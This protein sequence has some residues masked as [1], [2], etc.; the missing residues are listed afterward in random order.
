MAVD[1]VCLRARACVCTLFL[2][3][4][5]CSVCSFTPAHIH[6]LLVVTR[7]RYKASA[8]SHNQGN[9]A[10]GQFRNST[11]A[12]THVPLFRE[13]STTLCSRKFFR[14]VRV[15]GDDRNVGCRC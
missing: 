14:Y 10:K 9:K 1:D 15:P 13:M 5:L 11:R 3:L 2:C 7:S 4:S 6:K 12:H 8:H